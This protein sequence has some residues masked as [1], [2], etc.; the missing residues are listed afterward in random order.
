VSARRS[1]APYRPWKRSCAENSRR[2][3][4]AR[5]GGGSPSLVDSRSTACGSIHPTVGLGSTKF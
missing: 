5:P 4:L 2:S 1:P 3:P